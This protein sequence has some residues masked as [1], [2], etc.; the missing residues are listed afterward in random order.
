MKGIITKQRYT[1]A[2]IFVDHATR[3]GFPYQQ[4]STTS[5]ETV[6]AKRDFEAYALTY[7]VTIKHY[8]CDNGRFAD[9]LWREAID[10]ANQTMS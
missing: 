5:D 2:T 4:K 8:H 7:G 10:Q 6:A 3:L 1:V 9:N